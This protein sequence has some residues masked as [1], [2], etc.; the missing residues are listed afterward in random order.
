VAVAV[1]LALAVLLAPARE[2]PPQPSE[3]AIG[4]SAG[5]SHSPRWQF[6]PGIIEQ[7]GRWAPRLKNALRAVTAV[8][9]NH[10]RVRTT[11]APPLSHA[12]V[13]G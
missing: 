9:E 1:L 2:A 7:G 4:T 3:R 6:S 5:L 12:G 13:R 8:V 10:P 11:D